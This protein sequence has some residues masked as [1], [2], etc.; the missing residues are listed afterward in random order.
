[1]KPAVISKTI[2]VPSGSLTTSYV[3]GNIINV[4]NKNQ[5][6]MLTQ[7]LKGSSTDAR[8]KVEFAGDDQVFYQE[9]YLDNASGTTA[10]GVFSDPVLLHEYVLD[11]TGSYAIPVP[12]NAF[13]IRLSVK[14]TT[15]GTGTNMSIY[16]LDGIA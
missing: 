11:T 5:I 9:V 4:Q 12:I 14:A 16:I 8:I 13:Y 6:T 7:Y 3:A 10:A 2:A 1:M 15:S